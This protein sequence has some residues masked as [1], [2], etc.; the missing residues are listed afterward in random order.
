MTT[1]TTMITAAVADPAVP[2]E[3][4]VRRATAAAANLNPTSEDIMRN[5]FRIA[6]LMVMLAVMAASLGACRTR[7]QTGSLI[8]AGAGALGGY[9][10]GNEMDK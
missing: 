4:T 1:T 5:T 6:G 2:K 8:G 10:I 3:Q 7:A 9:M